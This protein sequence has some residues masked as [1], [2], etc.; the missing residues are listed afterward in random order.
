M[1]NQ[2]WIVSHKD[3]NSK[4]HYSPSVCL[5]L[6]LLVYFK[7]GCE[8][9]REHK[10]TSCQQLQICFE[11]FWPF[12][13]KFYEMVSWYHVRCDITRYFPV[14]IQ[15]D[16]TAAERYRTCS[17]TES[18]LGRHTS[19][20]ASCASWTVEVNSHLPRLAWR[21]HLPVPCLAWSAPCG[22]H[23][24]WQEVTGDNPQAL[25]GI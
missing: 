25:F 10:H 5:F 2:A 23:V 1:I 15:L 6:F 21:I 17:F 3:K 22:R 11:F 8:K 16:N 18:R 9:C 7:F 13:F 19:S 20:W 24:P 4:C 12:Q 14:L